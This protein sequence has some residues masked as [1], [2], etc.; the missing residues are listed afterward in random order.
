MQYSPSQCPSPPYCVWVFVCTCVCASMN[1]TPYHG[2]GMLCFHGNY[3]KKMFLM[4]LTISHKETNALPLPGLCTGH[5]VLKACLHDISYPRSPTGLLKCRPQGVI[6]PL[7][8]GTDSDPGDTRWLSL[9]TNQ[10]HYQSI[11]YQGE[12]TTSPTTDLKAL[13][14]IPLVCSY[15]EYS[16]VIH[17]G[18]LVQY[19]QNC[20]WSNRHIQQHDASHTTSRLVQHAPRT[21]PYR[22]SHWW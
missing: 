19:V 9:W 15:V 11:N 6:L 10:W 7:Q 8:S 16:I 3:T 21:M 18:Q 14:F 13:L 2:N 4:L 1:V 20:L 5:I 17:Y 22:S 12:K